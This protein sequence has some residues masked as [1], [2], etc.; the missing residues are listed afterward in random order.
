[1]QYNGGCLIGVEYIGANVYA[2]QPPN[3]TD[4]ASAASASLTFPS[5]PAYDGSFTPSTL[6]TWT[7]ALPTNTQWWAATAANSN[8]NAIFA[9]TVAPRSQEF[10]T[11]YS[12]VSGSFSQIANEGLSVDGIAISNGVAV[13][14]S[15]TDCR[16]LAYNHNGTAAMV[17]YSS[18]PYITTTKHAC[19]CGELAQAQI[20]EIP[21]NQELVSYKRAQVAP[22]ATEVKTMDGAIRRYVTG[23][24]SYTLSATWRW[25]DNG[26]TAATLSG[27]FR[28]AMAN[29]YPLIVYIPAGIYYDGAHLDLVVPTND[30]AVTMPAPGVYE[31][32]I[33]GSCQ[34]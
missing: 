19:Y 22:T 4:Y 2:A 33:E 23:S 25:S 29:A 31:L 8:A 27:I 13:K 5:W 28:D 16:A 15:A 3:P 24:A 34:P 21:N 1:M 14:N 30:P 10:V 17:A 11:F 32:T 6:A 20:V 26:T 9:S 18:Y 7:T 12:T